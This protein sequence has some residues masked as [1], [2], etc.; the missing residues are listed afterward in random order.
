MSSL[1]LLD[2]M[3]AVCYYL[4]GCHSGVGTMNVTQHDI[5][6][7]MLIIDDMGISTNDTHSKYKVDTFTTVLSI[8]NYIWTMNVCVAEDGSVWLWH[9][10]NTLQQLLSTSWKVTQ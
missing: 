6:M 10:T 4:T 7:T 2:N 1:Y 9:W 5:I 3:S 8:I